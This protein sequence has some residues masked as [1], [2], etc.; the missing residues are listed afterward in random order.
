VAL[1]W[2][3]LGVGLA[4]RPRYHSVGVG[5]VAGVAVAVLTA[6]IYT[7]IALAALAEEVGPDAVAPAARN[8]EFVLP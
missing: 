7:V 8:L 3:G 6:S 1:A 5:I 2:I 4:K